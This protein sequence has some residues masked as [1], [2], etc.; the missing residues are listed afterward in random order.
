MSPAQFWEL[1]LSHHPDPE[2][3]Y[4]FFLALEDRE[5]VTVTV[6]ISGEKEISVTATGNTDKAKEAAAEL[7]KLITP[8]PS[9][10]LRLPDPSFPVQGNTLCLTLT[11]DRVFTKD[12]EG[13][14]F[15]LLLS[16]RGHYSMET[17]HFP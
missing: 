2:P 6:S 8:T 1:L 4:L 11:S 17:H 14:R 12:T 7:L 5:V 10:S 9:S 15:H 3:V 16:L 13:C